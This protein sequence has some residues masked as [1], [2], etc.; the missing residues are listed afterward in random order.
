VMQRVNVK[1]QIY[2]KVPFLGTLSGLM[3]RLL[4]TRH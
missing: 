4:A 1:N 2:S 3:R